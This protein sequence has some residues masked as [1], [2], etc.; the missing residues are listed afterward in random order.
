MPFCV[1]MRIKGETVKKCAA[2]WMPCKRAASYCPPQ[3]ARSSCCPSYNGAL[4]VTRRWTAAWPCCWH[5]RVFRCLLHG[6][7]TEARRVLASEVLQRLQVPAVKTQVGAAGGWPGG[8]CCYRSAAPWLGPF[9]G[10]AAGAGPAHAGAG[11]WSN[12]LRRAGPAGLCWWG[13]Y[14]HPEYSGLMAMC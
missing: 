6:M 7:R 12:C 1:A 11:V 5:A 9:A 2:F 13:S 3:R 8:P 4:E 14:T 10:G